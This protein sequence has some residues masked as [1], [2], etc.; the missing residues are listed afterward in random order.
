MASKVFGF[1][2]LMTTI[3]RT[4]LKMNLDMDLLTI[5]AELSL[6]MMLDVSKQCQNRAK[7]DQVYLLGIEQLL[8]D[9]MELRLEPSESIKLIEA[10]LSHYKRSMDI[11]S[12]TILCMRYRLA[13]LHRERGS[14]DKAEEILLQIVRLPERYPEE[15]FQRNTYYLAAGN[16]GEMYFQ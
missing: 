14:R 1:S 10:R 9:S 12:R 15:I 6:K 16:L 5:L 8:L 11:R 4:I 3:L 13:I 2:H 7:I